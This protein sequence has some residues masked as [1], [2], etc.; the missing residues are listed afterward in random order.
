MS[1]ARI[2]RFE[3][4]GA[5]GGP[6]WGDVRTAGGGGGRPP[7]VLC[8]GFKGNKDWGFLPML[9]DRLA[10]AGMTVISFNFS[11]S[12]VGADGVGYPERE[13]FARSTF[14]NDVAD[15]GTICR[16]LEAG[17]IVDGLVGSSSYGLLGYSRGGGTAVLH[18]AANPAVRSLATWAA[19][20]HTNRWDADSVTAWRVEGKR[21]PPGGENGEDLFFY[22][23]MLDD[24]QKNQR[25]LDITSAAGKIVAP[26][27]IIHGAADEFVP[28]AEA[29][30]LHGAAARTNTTLRVIEGG[31]HTFG[32]VGQLD[33]AVDQ[34]I[35][36]FSRH[37]F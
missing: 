19:I 9:A 13:R 36:W 22:T 23:D 24:I 25:T 26:W 18:A 21:V 31:N 30:T 34:T 10:R 14:S 2:T 12:G 3:L 7:I 37:L 8:H 6:L 1:T 33:Y 11:G 32:A 29:K 20:S 17:N 5:D 15:L 4:T 35:D 27:L 28:V 16:A